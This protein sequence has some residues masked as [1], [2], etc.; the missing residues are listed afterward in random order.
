MPKKRKIAVLII[1]R[2]NYGRLKPVL[3]AINEHPDLE[4]QL[5]VGS[6]MLLYRFGND[7][8]FIEEDG[9][10]INAKINMIVEGGTPSTMAQSAGVGLMSLPPILE[11]LEPDIFL[12][13]ADRFEIL[14]A[15]VAA[16]Y[17]NIPL[18]HTLGGEITGTI[19]E[20][21]RHAVTKLA[22]LH[23]TAHKPAADRIVS[24]GEN[25][26]NV[27]VVGNPSLDLAAKTP[28]KIDAEKF[29]RLYG[30]TG[31]PIDF[32]QPFILAYQHSVTTEFTDAQ[33]Q[34]TET[35]EALNGINIQTIMIWPNPDAGTDLLS[36]GIRVFKE[37]NPDSKIHFFRSFSAED[38]LE[39]LKHAV[40]A[41]GNSSSAI[42][43][44]GFFGTPAV[45]I[46]T[47]QAGREQCIN[48]LNVGY[49][50]GEIETAIRKQLQHGRYE[51]DYFFG[52][53]KSGK[54]VAEILATHTTEI[55]K[56][57]NPKKDYHLIKNLIK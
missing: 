17:M 35:L 6:S 20:S 23:F 32:S 33:K 29:N 55:Q 57:F 48:A 45:N 49:N 1:N 3:K 56:Q 28:E 7:V 12:V 37:K 41:V 31:A 42:M 18:A 51:P 54:R 52:D 38:Y 13:N 44:G 26:E 21:V 2:A 8:R 19:D 15:A 34:I 9:F 24:M 5:I 40:C 11:Q 10:K 16:A 39:L 46:G 22:H 4:L 43:E 50:A 27:F 53:G 14:P 47:R 36:K 25:P 30:G